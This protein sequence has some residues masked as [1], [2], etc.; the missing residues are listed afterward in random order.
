[1]GKNLLIPGADFSEN[2][3]RIPF[4][5]KVAKGKT[6]TAYKDTAEI[7]Y[8]YDS[9]SQFGTPSVFE[10]IDGTGTLYELNATELLNTP[11]PVRQLFSS[12]PHNGSTRIGANTNNEALLM[13]FIDT[14]D[15]NCHE[16]FYGCSSLVSVS[17]ASSKTTDCVGMFSGCTNLS[18]I[19]LRGFNPMCANKMFMQCKAI[20]SF[21]LTDRWTRAERT[22]LMFY[23]CSNM[24]DCDLSNLVGNATLIDMSSM[25]L[26]CSKLQTLNLDNLI[27]SS[28]CSMPSMFLYCS[29]LTTISVRNSNE[30]T[31]TKILDALRASS[32]TR[33]YEPQDD[34][35]NATTVA[36]CTKIVKVAG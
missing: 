31:K 16:M 29:S 28:N 22:S 25:F 9:N 32:S 1:M 17:V 30:E 10:E 14:D 15:L 12:N 8:G 21:V 35:G 33:T 18:E 4:R 34:N 20:T 23:G 13:A 19:K 36:L 2:Y 3:V 6:L 11:N 26:E 5:V 27:V 24:T 7:S